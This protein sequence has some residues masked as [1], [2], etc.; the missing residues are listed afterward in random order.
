MKGKDITAAMPGYFLTR[1]SFKPQVVYIATTEQRGNMSGWSRSTRDFHTVYL[2]QQVK[3]SGD[4]TDLQ[5]DECGWVDKLM[6]NQLTDA[7]TQDDALGYLRRRR[8]AGERSEYQGKM[9][10]KHA[11]AFIAAMVNAGF[12]AG[13]DE[14]KGVRIPRASV[15]KW[16]EDQGLTLDNSEEG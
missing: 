2:A 3:L 8:E 1:D 11:D 7:L 5:V 12:P 16:C 15:V 13:Y 4:G 10:D 6:P 14:W 9:Y